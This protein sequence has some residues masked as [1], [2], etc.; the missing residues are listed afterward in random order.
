[1]LFGSSVQ[2]VESPV[3][4]KKSC[5]AVFQTDSS[6]HFCPSLFYDLSF[7]NMETESHFACMGSKLTC[8]RIF[9]IWASLQ[10]RGNH[11]LSIGPS[12]SV[13]KF[14]A[15][16]EEKC[17]RRRPQLGRGKKKTFPVLSRLVHGEECREFSNYI[18]ESMRYGGTAYAVVSR[19][20]RISHCVSIFTAFASFF[21]RICYYMWNNFVTIFQN[22]RS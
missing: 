5:L 4:K 15:W 12:F 17:P 18:K 21:S 8:S 1:M 14:I 22:S 2:P 6:V 9:F 16:L 7:R 19:W 10:K 11:S 13:T 20:Q 3:K